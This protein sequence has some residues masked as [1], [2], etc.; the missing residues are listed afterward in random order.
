ME[1]WFIEVPIGTKR[2]ESVSLD[3]VVSVRSDTISEDDALE[4]ARDVVT[5]FYAENEAE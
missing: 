5:N 1:L 4:I 3:D 2:L